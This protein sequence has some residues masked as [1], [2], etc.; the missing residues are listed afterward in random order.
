MDNEVF[1]RLHAQKHFIDATFV[2]ISATFLKPQKQSLPTG[3]IEEVM[4]KIA[5]FLVN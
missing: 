1:S 2:Q 3:V 5:N 4:D